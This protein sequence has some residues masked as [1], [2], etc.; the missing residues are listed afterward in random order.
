MDKPALDYHELASFDHKYLIVDALKLNR[1]SLAR[2][3]RV[4]PITP[5]NFTF[6]VSAHTRTAEWM[7]IKSTPSSKHFGKTSL[8]KS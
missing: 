2:N 1:Y 4:Y 7:R 3:Y 5:V 6:S 8:P